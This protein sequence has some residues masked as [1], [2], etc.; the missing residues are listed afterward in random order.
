MVVLLRP[1]VA[2][3]TLYDLNSD[4]LRKQLDYLLGGAKTKKFKE[5]VLGA[6]VPHSSYIYSGEVAAEF[7]SGV[8]KSNFVIL[9]SN[10]STSGS[11]FA[12]MKNSL[13]K[14]PIGEVVVDDFFAERL[15]KECGLVEFDAFVHESEF[16][17]EVQ[18]PFLLHKMTEF[19]M[20]PLTINDQM[21]DKAFLENCRIVGK[22]VGKLAKAIGGWKVIGSSDLSR[23]MQKELTYLADKQLIRS[24]S[25]LDAKGFFEKIK[26]TGM[27]VC[28]Y[29]TVAAAI[30][31]VKEMGAKKARVLRYGTI[32]DLGEDQLPITG[33]ASIIFY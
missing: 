15:L 33:Y 26:E 20:L 29:G 3:G 12:V 6:L 14:T 27:N 8:E 9:G 19:K 31:A 22:T 1:P 2:A 17:I 11:T 21:P 23:T 32:A 7:Y 30:Y 18:L 10:H 28:G 24:I 16:S 25:K 5:R 13:W 4:N